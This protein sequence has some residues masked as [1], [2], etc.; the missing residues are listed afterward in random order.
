MKAIYLITLLTLISSNTSAQTSPH[1]IDPE[2]GLPIAAWVLKENYNLDVIRINYGE[3]EIL[4]DYYEYKHHGRRYHAFFSIRLDRGIE[5]VKLI[6]VQ[7]FVP[8]SKRWHNV[9]DEEQSNKEKQ[10]EEKFASE[11]KRKISNPE[12]IKQ[13]QK[14]FFR[15]VETNAVMFQNATPLMGEQWFDAFLKGHEIKWSLTMTHIEQ[16]EDGKYAIT[17]VYRKPS[18]ELTM[19]KTD[20]RL[21]IKQIT[22]AP[23]AA[24][25][26]KGKERDILGVCES[27]EYTYD[28]F[29]LTLRETDR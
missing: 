17:Y 20:D 14:R 27:L 16:L 10:I 4:S 26:S 28:Q 12:V 2:V 6:E 23:H 18:K 19:S 29:T 22:N 11:L 21:F 24:S 3:R 13:A 8:Q 25:Y 9:L 7:K 5:M 1:G 15:S